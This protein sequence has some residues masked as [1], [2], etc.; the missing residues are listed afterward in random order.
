MI[1]D[2]TIDK[3]KWLLLAFLGILLLKAEQRWHFPN[4]YLDT[5]A[6]AATYSNWLEGKG[7]VA[8]DEEHDALTS[9]H[10]FPPI[11]PLVLG[12]LNSFVKEWTISIRLLDIFVLLFIFLG[13]E[14]LFRI[15]LKKKWTVQMLIFLGIGLAPLQYATGSGLL[16]L[17]FFTWAL[18]FVLRFLNSFQT[19]SI[20]FASL[21]FSLCFWTRPAYLPFVA[22]IPALVF[23]SKHKA[24]RRKFYLVLGGASFLQFTAASFLILWQRQGPNL[25]PKE[26]GFFPSNLLESSPFLIKSLLFWAWP[27]EI[28]IETAFPAVYFALKLFLL[29][30]NSILLFWLGF[31]LYRRVKTNSKSI[32]FLG[33]VIILINLGFLLFLSLTQPTEDWNEFKSW[34]YVAEDRYYLPSMLLIL[35]VFFGLVYRYKWIRALLLGLNI[36][37]LLFWGFMVTKIHFETDR[38]IGFER[39][40]TRTLE[41]FI[42]K[43][44]ESNLGQFYLKNDPHNY[45]LEAYQLKGSDPMK[46]PNYQILAKDGF[47]LPKETFDIVYDHE[48]WVFV[49]VGR[50]VELLKD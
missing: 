39:S 48:N 25:I 27:Q 26:T 40:Y 19:T 50:D 24:N 49:K 10:R 32:F 30:I 42:L 37:Y 4:I 18:S 11:Y 21:L 44:Q 38:E 17:C 2:K 41:L 36:L 6:Q 35:L 5:L 33:L 15:Q 1:W 31:Y 47:D 45:L 43:A 22:V 3:K 46:F 12:T 34:T 7:W 28:S 16:A 8:Y 23:F 14:K 29:L 13:L 20:I 9:M